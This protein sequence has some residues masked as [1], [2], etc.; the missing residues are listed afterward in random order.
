MNKDSFWALIES[1]REVGED[2]NER[3][4]CVIEQLSQLPPADILDFQRHIEECLAET[5]RWDL[6]AVAFIIMGGCSDDSFEYFRGWLIIQG[7][8]YYEAAL[9]HAELAAEATEPGMDGYECED[10]L[11]G[12]RPVYKQLT[13]TAMPPTGVLRPSAPMGVPW[14]EADLPRLFPKLCEKYSA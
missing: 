12:A 7:R 2:C 5:Y 14:K 4:E 11:F 13:R 6:W 3:A 8:S 9:K 1:A 10:I